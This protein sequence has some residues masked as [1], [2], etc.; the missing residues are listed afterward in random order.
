M[1]QSL[2]T[3][4]WINEKYYRQHIEIN[5]NCYRC[6]DGTLMIEV[7]NSSGKVAFNVRDMDTIEYVES[8]KGKEPTFISVKIEKEC[9]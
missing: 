9:E 8:T 3:P 2:D 4:S 1:N 5:S 6:P 7:Y